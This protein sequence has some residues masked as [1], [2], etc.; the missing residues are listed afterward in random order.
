MKMAEKID[1]EFC[2]LD[3]KRGRVALAKRINQAT[4]R[5]LKSRIPVT[6]RGYITDVWGNDDGTSIE[7]QVEVSDAVER[8]RS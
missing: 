4:S 1:S 8:V 3:V 2:L 5:G 7:F 6:I